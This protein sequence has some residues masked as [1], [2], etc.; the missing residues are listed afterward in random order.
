MTDS[1]RFLVTTWEG[2]GNM[3]PTLTAVRK[4]VASGH[5]VRALGERCN[6]AQIEAAGA[7]FVPWSEA[8]NRQDRTPESQ[9]FRDWAAATPQEGLMSVVRDHW[10]APA[11]A[12]AR[13]VL[14]ELRIH[15]ADLVVTSEA[16]FG[17]MAGCES[18]G[19]PFVVLSV[20]VSLNPLPGVPPLGPGLPPARTDEERAMHAAIAEA[21]QAM[22]DSGLP[23]LNATR[24]QLGLPPLE[25]LLDQLRA[26]RRELLATSPA[27]DFPCDALPAKVRYV[28]PLLDDPQWARFWSSPW[29]DSDERPL[30]LVGFS[31]TFQDHAATLQR[32]IDALAPLRAR[33]LVT[34]GSSIR[35][36]E[37]RASEN[38]VVVASAPHSV[39]MRQASLV[40]THGGHG[41]V[42]RGLANRV[43]LLVMPLGRDQAD[44]AVRVTE[45]SAGLSLGPDAPVEQ[46]RAACERLLGEPSFRENARRLGDVV[47]ADA[48]SSTVVTELEAA[49]EPPASGG[50]PHRPTDRQDKPTKLTDRPLS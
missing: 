8:P 44:N 7:T 22:F 15:P 18:V 35:A 49:A 17:V 50:R 32:V 20:N 46:I 13:D 43:P 38:T 47:A 34:L 2:G 27:F 28:G 39:V 11:M 23:A 3:P 1:K 6:Q 24:A 31:T 41:T 30:V 45:R 33:V 42:I 19:Q 26:A 25:H 10:C 16:L 48:E 29:S 4:L 36:H 5:R 14:A 40:V 12:Y 37:L 9:P 21:C